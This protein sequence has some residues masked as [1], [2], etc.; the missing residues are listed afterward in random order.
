MVQPSDFDPGLHPQQY[1]TALTGSLTIDI[2]S[3][4]DQTLRLAQDI[5][6][7]LAYFNERSRDYDGNAAVLGT[8]GQFAD[9]WRKIH[10]V[11]KALWD[12]QPLV[13]ETV[14]EVLM[15]LVG[16]CLLA[17]NMLAERP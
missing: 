6:R 3:P 7:T 5:H 13:G 12:E 15:D 17:I 16:H 4:T 8:K 10:K 2:K 11:K 14:E 9:I 1:A